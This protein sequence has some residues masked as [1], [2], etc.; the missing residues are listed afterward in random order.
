[1]RIPDLTDLECS[2][3]EDYKQDLDVVPLDISEED[4]H[5]VDTWLRGAA[6]PSGTYALA[7][8][9]W[10]LHFGTSSDSLREEMVECSDFLANESSPWTAHLS[11][12]ETRMFVLHK[13]L[14]VR[15]VGIRD[16]C[17]HLI[18]KLFLRTRGAQAKEASRSVNLSASL[19]PV[20]DGA[21]HTLRD[22][23]EPVR[24]ETGEE[25]QERLYTEYQAQMRQYLAHKMDTRE[26]E[27]TMATIS[28]DRE[29]E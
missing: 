10:M 8:H 19:E 20:L 12:M 17:C 22:K 7:F 14:G 25:R 6:G 29:E 15:P 21:I 18:S 27:R 9:S 28:E 1:M 2:S 11:I 23:G 16:R 24:G 26:S 13:C 4:V 5:Q 3:F